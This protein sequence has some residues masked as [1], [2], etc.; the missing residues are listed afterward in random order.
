MMK[1]EYTKKETDT[2]KQFIK[3]MFFSEITKLN[4]EKIL[5][6]TMDIDSDNNSENCCMIEDL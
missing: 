3:K 1:Q 6:R 2:K 4:N 5:Q